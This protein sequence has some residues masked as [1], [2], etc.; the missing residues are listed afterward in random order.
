M[1]IQ[2]IG[3]NV[4][5][6]IKGCDIL[7]A[8][9]GYFM[10]DAINE[11]PGRQMSKETIRY[12]TEGTCSRAIEIEIENGRV[13]RCSFEK[14]CS[15]NAQGLCRLVAG[16]EVDEIIRKLSGIQCQNGTSCPDQLAKALMQWRNRAAN[17]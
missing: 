10:F 14:G 12:K 11:R 8:S 3:F 6:R 4:I 2:S 1:N 7:P 5:M 13:T 9:N 15:G 17:Q 16:S